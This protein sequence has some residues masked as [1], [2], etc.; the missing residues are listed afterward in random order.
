MYFNCPERMLNNFK[1][2][3]YDWFFYIVIIKIKQ[4]NKPILRD[5]WIF[6][7]LVP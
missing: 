1:N 6:C 3:I 4:S 5:E 7:I 2:L